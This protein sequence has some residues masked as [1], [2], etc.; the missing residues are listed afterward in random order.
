MTTDTTL[1]LTINGQ[2]QT[3]SLSG[4]PSL[5][6]LLASLAVPTV[7]G[8]AVA[9]NDQVVPR[10]QWDTHALRDQDRVEIIRATQGG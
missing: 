1:S 3:L 8:I 2:P 9:V 10:S 7:R 4:Q 5:S 6:A